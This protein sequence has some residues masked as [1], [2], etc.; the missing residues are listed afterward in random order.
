MFLHTNESTYDHVIAYFLLLTTF[1]GPF[2][3]RQR[4]RFLYV[5]RIVVVTKSG[6][7]YSDLRYASQYR[8]AKRPD[9]KC[10]IIFTKNRLDH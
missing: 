4:N 5:W 7:I 6:L 10:S 3:I 8:N 1:N 2:Y 9:L